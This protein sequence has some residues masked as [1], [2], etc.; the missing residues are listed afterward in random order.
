M[1]WLSF[2]CAAWVLVGCIQDTPELEPLKLSS[3]EAQRGDTVTGT[4]KVEDHNGDLDGGK[5]TITL[6]STGDGRVLGSQDLPISLDDG[7]RRASVSFSFRIT[8]TATRGPAIVE[9][10]I[11]DKAGHASEPRTASLLVK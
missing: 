9:L 8:A 4:A 10:V 7:T 5:M 3:S 6:R 11:V 1:K 2:A